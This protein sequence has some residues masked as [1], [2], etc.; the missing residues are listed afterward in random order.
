MKT[1][2]FWQSPNLLSDALLPFSYL[3]D[4][5]RRLKRASITPTT[6]PVPIICVGNLT[7]G[8]A[9]KTPVAIHI[10]QRLKDNHINAFFLS[11][12]YGGSLTGPVLVDK[13]KHTAGDVGDE[14]LLLAKILPTV[15]AKDRVSGAKFAME[16]GAAAIVMD[17]GFQ[18]HSLEKTLSLVVIDGQNG[19]GNGRLLPAGPL[20]EPA[21]EGLKRAQAIIVINPAPGAPLPSGI[22]VLH[23]RTQLDNFAEFAG[24]KLLAFCGLAYPNKFFTLLESQDTTLLDT[25]SFPDHH[26]YTNADIEALIARAKEQ[27]A[28]LVTTAK[29]WVRLPKALRDTVAVAHMKLAFDDEASLGRLIHTIPGLHGK[30]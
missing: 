8:G 5:A 13:Q 17:D 19:L 12:G 10:G 15:V 7:A 16:H 27:Q 28:M 29:D 4:I 26:P 20:R 9:G 30:Q 2:T 3:Y 14:P 23:A 21:A 1:P 11:R 24:K 6:L 25:V 18:N 22:T